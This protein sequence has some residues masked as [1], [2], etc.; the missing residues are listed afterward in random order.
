VVSSVLRGSAA[1]RAGIDPGD[2]IVGIAGQRLAPAGGSTNGSMEGASVDAALRGRSA[3]DEVD[4]LVARDGRMLLLRAKLDPPRLD[5]VKIVPLPDAP[6]DA[7]KAFQ[8][9]TG[10]PYAAW[11]KASR[12][13]P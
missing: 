8:A 7:R 6:F 1:W 5:R 12:S 10:R 4:V 9:W 2:E 11:E 3:G 13:A